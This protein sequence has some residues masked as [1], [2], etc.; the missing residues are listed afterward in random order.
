MTTHQKTAIQT[1]QQASVAFGQAAKQEEAST[2]PVQWTE[3]EKAQ[4]QADARREA[5]GHSALMKRLE[6]GL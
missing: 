2:T 1:D 4:I 5:S 3:L 6:R